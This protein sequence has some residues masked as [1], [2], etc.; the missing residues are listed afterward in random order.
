MAR[1]CL[2]VLAALTTFRRDGSERGMVESLR[3]LDP[4]GGKEGSMAITA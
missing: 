4:N 1:P 2:K 3:R